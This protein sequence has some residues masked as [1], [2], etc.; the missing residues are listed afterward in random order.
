[1]SSNDVCEKCGSRARSE[2]GF[3]ED[4]GARWRI[5]A[6]PQNSQG[7][8]SGHTSSPLSDLPARLSSVDIVEV[9]PKQAWLAILLAAIAGPVGLFYCTVT[10]AITMFLV[11]IV[12]QLW[13]GDAS[14]ILVLPIC[15]AWAWKVSRE[16]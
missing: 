9:R 10:G 4:C 6:A 3:C 11:S 5:V 7:A 12:F 15:I 2:Y 13:L 16:W 1:M 14:L 8:N